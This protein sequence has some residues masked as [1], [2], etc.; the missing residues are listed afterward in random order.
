MYRYFIN[1]GWLFYEKSYRG[2]INADTKIK[3]IVV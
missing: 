3:G 2:R 1:L